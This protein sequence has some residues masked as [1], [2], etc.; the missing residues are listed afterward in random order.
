MRF[1]YHSDTAL[2][3]SKI[4]TLALGLLAEIPIPEDEGLLDH[5]SA[6]PFDIAGLFADRGLYDGTSIQRLDAVASVA[7]P[8][9]RGGQQMAEKLNTSVSYWR[10]YVMYEGSEWELGCDPRTKTFE[11]ASVTATSSTATKP[12]FWLSVGLACSFGRWLVVKA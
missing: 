12:A 5:A 3:V 4:E 2:P 11:P 6:L 9:V 10:E 7:L 1:L 8:V